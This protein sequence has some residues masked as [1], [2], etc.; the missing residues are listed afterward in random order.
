MSQYSDLRNYRFFH[1]VQDN[2]SNGYLTPIVKQIIFL[3]E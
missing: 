2:M 1:L 3:D